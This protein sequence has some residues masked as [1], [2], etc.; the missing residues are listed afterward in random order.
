MQGLALP[1]VLHHPER[2]I[3]V[4]VHGDDFTAVGPK[5]ELDRFEKTLRQHY[6]L[7]VGQRLGPGPTTIR[8]APYSSGSFGGLRRASSTRPITDSLSGSSRIVT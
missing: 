7:A 4:S 1:C 6:E 8:R 5:P 3:A 2:G